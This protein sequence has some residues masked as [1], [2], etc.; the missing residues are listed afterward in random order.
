MARGWITLAGVGLVVLG[1]GGCASGPEVRLRVER[2]DQA[3][4]VTPLA[5]AFVQAVPL[6]ASP[7]PLPLS[8]ETIDEALTASASTG[9]TNARGEFRFRMGG[10]RPHDLTVSCPASPDLSPGA[11]VWRGRI[12]TDG[13]IE[14]I[15]DQVVPETPPLRVTALSAP[16]SSSKP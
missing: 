11:P 1:A 15:T 4:R 3:G 2:V 5:M 9:F 10:R 6:N 13:R 8:L 7:V 12:D 16:P 14:P